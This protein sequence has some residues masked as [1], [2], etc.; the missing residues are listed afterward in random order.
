VTQTT[1]YLRYPHLSG[2]TLAFV[3]DDDV[4]L[5]DLPG[6]GASAR[7]WRVTADRVPV[8]APRLSPDGT[9]LAWT[10]TREGV[11][12][13]FALP[14]DGGEANRLTYWGHPRT[15]VIGWASADEVMVR[16][17][18]GH[19][20]RFYTFA[21]TVPFE[22]GQPSQLPYGNL[23]HLAIA[24]PGV[25]GSPVVLSRFYSGLSYM[26]KGYRGGAAGQ[27]W[28]DREGTGEFERF[29]ADLDG[30]LGDPMW[31]DGRVVFHSDHD[32]VADLYSARPDGTDLRRHTTG[33]DGYYLRHAATDGVRIIFQRAGRLWLMEDLEDDPRPLDIRLPG[34]RTAVTRRPVDAAQH[35]GDFAPDKTGRA[36][37]VEVRGT[38]HWLTHKDGPARGIGVEDGVR[39]RLPVV[40]G[41][42]GRAAWVTD[43]DGRYSIEV[44]ATDGSERRRIATGEFGYVLDLVASPDGAHLAVTTRD[45]R[46]LLIDVEAG[47]VRVVAAGEGKYSGYPRWGMVFA[48]EPAFSPDSKWLAWSE[49]TAVADAWRI[50]V[51]AVETLETI[52]VTEARFRDWN[53]VFTSDGKHLVFLSARTFDTYEE[54]MYFD[55]SF[56]PS[57]R[58]YLVPLAETE[59]SPFDPEL[60]G[61]P[62]GEDGIEN[63]ENTENTENTENPDDAGK[64][65]AIPA[66][67][68]DAHGITSRAVPFPVPSGTYSHLAAVKGGVV[69]LTRQVDG[70]LGDTL[71]GSGQ[72]QHRPALVRFDLVK[73]EHQTLIDE[74]DRYAV[75]GDGARVVASDH[76]VLS[77]RPADKRDD[78]KPETVDLSRIRVTV[79]PDR[80]RVNAFLEAWRLQVEN[81][82]KPAMDG[83]D[84]PA[85]RD[86]YLP[87]VPAAATDDDFADLLW[88]LQGEL[89]TSHAYVTAPPSSRDTEASR[90][91]LLGADLAPDEDSRW[92]I[93]RILP[94]DSSVPAAR[95]PLLAPGVA[96]RVGDAILAVDGAA[97]PPNVGPA[98]L[99]AGK[100]GQPTELTLLSAA[101]GTARA[102][103]VVPIADEVPLRYQAWVADRRAYVLEKS[104]GRLGYIHLP[105]QAEPGWAEFHRDLRSQVVRDGL[106][107]D[108]RGNRGGQT[109]GLVVEKLM[110]K[111]IAWE[112][113]RGEI[114]EPYPAYAPRGPLVSVCDEEAG[115]DGDIIN[116]AFKDYGVPVVGTRTWGGVIGI[117]ECFTLV[118]GTWVTQPRYGFVFD[119]VGLYG[120]EN[121]GCEPTVTVDFA[122]QDFVAGRDPQLE[123]AIE[124][125]LD[126]LAKEPP[127]APR[128]VPGVYER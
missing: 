97:V 99:L 21:H 70:A 35:L 10:S 127:A 58:P 60:G 22:G 115:S 51:A 95:S 43:A 24:E 11:V 57:V 62:V 16:G 121:H 103:V 82:V 119:S 7:A 75:T 45:S 74:L 108:T 20:H 54:D 123:K 49:R 112:Y 14:V 88:E 59:P 50:R 3:A 55:Y 56:L 63:A 107:V 91:G 84:W 124:I 120:L 19:G 4:W 100:A 111:A 31:F 61:R 65:S 66:T 37:A 68:I 40:L 29:L 80:E 41:E 89:K 83:I 47:T 2:T 69:W 101:T 46:L 113:A 76:G 125:A 109:S 27:L 116:Q 114:P 96:A 81:Y 104:G 67:V 52:E 12:E 18:G 98:G 23:K 30:N 17:W 86:R 15:E 110:R 38:L 8:R 73:R 42:T 77:V 53:P 1:T 6:I 118:D 102:V 85:A 117:D 72:D 44:A 28:I 39:G 25:D 122:P 92:R 13:A 128:S 9:R 71:A 94:G 87:L 5:T 26:W 79:R 33:E 36:S 90:Q 34:A 105:D 64:D 48:S 78:A 93:V 106:V 126:A 32:G